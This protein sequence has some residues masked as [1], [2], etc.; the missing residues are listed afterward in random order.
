MDND[1]RV[2][3]I[4]LFDRTYASE[5]PAM[6]AKF[7]IALN[8]ELDANDRKAGSVDLRID[9]VEKKSNKL[10]FNSSGKGDL[11]GKNK[12]IVTHLDLSGRLVFKDPGEFT[13][14]LYVNTN[15]LAEFD[16]AV[17]KDSLSTKGKK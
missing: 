11:P 9:I 17:Q 10:Y 5:F 2:S 7:V 16:F 6:V 4:N 15:L 1:G 13:A 8:V 14:R 12:T 3:L